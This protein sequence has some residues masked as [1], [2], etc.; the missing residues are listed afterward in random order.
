MS[1][2][3]N[4][5]YMVGK[6]YKRAQEVRVSSD[7]QAKAEAIALGHAACGSM[8]EFQLMFTAMGKTDPQ[9]RIE[10]LERMMEKFIAKEIGEDVV[11]GG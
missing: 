10:N 3:R 6:D 2:D 4:M 11:E 9:V 8:G 7:F 5:K 1:M